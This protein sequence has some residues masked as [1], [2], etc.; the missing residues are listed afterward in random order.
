MKL[1][2]I[3]ILLII[4]IYC[5]SIDKESRIDQLFED[6][7]GQVP[8]ASLLVIKKGNKIFEKSFGLANL[9]K[10]TAVTPNTNFRLASV[11][12]QF[13]AMCILQLIEQE[14]L[15]LKTNLIQ[16]FRNFPEYG[17]TITIKHLLQHTSGLIDYEDLIPDTVTIQVLDKDVLEMMKQQ[18]STYFE[19]GTEYRYS[20]SA[21][22]V[23]SVII[24]KISGKTFAKYLKQYIFTPVGMTNTI[25]LEEGISTV[26][27]RA[28][29][30]KFENGKF[31]FKDQSITSAVL[32]DG[33]IYSSIS[34]L[35]KWDQILYSDVLISTETLDL[36]FSHGI[37]KNGELIDYSFGWY[38]KNFKGNKCVY[39][40]GSTSGF[41]NVFFRIPK[42]KLSV[43]ILTNRAEP[44]LRNI[45]EQ[46]S[47]LYL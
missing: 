34:D 38:L 22:A 42:Q 43:I 2:S 32:G 29:G 12:K 5:C 13:T 24:E 40:T 31:V 20:N 3:V 30:Y 26:N 33:G 37:L 45:A 23:L 4:F 36:I 14:K 47:E 21:Y 35:Y 25:A 41:R 15:N 18:D 39:H 44:D 28:M 7:K 1:Y 17:K 9:A 10:E 46:I 11:T 27:N 19:P 16:I 8:G 6:Y